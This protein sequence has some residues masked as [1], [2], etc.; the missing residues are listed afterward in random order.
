MYVNLLNGTH[1]SEHRGLVENILRCEFGFDGVV[2]TDWITGRSMMSKGAK[3]PAPAA[4]KIA[5][6]GGDLVMPGEKRDVTDIL[7]TRKSGALSREQLEINATRV[8]ALIRR[9]KN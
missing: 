8:L 6:A 5:A 3:Y 9:L 4:D 2:M 7:N 1:T